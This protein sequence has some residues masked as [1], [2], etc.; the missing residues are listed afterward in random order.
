MIA[1]ATPIASMAYSIELAPEVSRKNERMRFM[2][3]LVSHCGHC[4][5]KNWKNCQS[6]DS[7]FRKIALVSARGA[8]A[9]LGFTQIGN[10]RACFAEVEPADPPLP[11]GPARERY[12]GLHHRVVI[13]RHR[14]W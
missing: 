9:D 2:F 4:A 7:N 11:A 6:Y 14:N 10:I 1:T 3:R 8:R 12:R 5:A 13:E